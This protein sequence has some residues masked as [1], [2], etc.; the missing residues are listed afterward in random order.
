M[1]QNKNPIR[2]FEPTLD[3]VTE[4]DDYASAYFTRSWSGC[5]DF[6]IETNYNTVHAQDL[7]RGRIVMFDKDVKKCGI[8]T[9]VKKEVGAEGKG[10]EIVT[11]SGYE[12]KFILGRRIVLPTTG[13]AYY[14]ETDNAETVM[15]NLV[16]LNGGPSTADADRKFSLLAIETDGGTGDTYLEKTRWTSSLLNELQT[17]S[18]TTGMGFYIYLDLTTKK[19]V[20]ATAS[21]LDRSASQAVNPR[22]IFSK[23]YDTLQSAEIN[24]ND[25]NYVNYAFVGGQGEGTART[26]REVYIETTEPTDLDRREMFVDARDLPT[27]AELDT[28]GGQKLEEYSTIITTDGSPLVYSPL[29]YGTD[30]NLGDIVSIEA[31]GVSRD[32][33]ITSAKESWSPS[34]YTLDFSFDKVPQTIQAQVT[35]AMTSVKNSVE[36]RGAGII[37]KGGNDTAGYYIKYGNG[38]ME[39]WGSKPIDCTILSNTPVGTYGWSYYYGSSPISFPVQFTSVQS[40]VTSNGDGISSRYAL[41]TGLGFTLFA[42]N[43]TA[44]NQS[45]ISWAA[46]GTW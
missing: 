6:S 43:D 31:Y 42:V 13:S 25:A 19:F 20:F 10:S 4:F 2:I 22:A 34:S 37:E 8:I 16:D 11:A 14:E 3:L 21:G 33:R 27:T 35:S 38:L 18:T 12:L 29:V 26:I 17:C 36:N 23:D 32:V 44:V 28:R 30:Y 39:Q 40:V 41:V 24:D 46:F 45:Y 7:T 1:S 9:S 5:G 15:K